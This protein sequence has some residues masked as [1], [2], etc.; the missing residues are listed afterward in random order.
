MPLNSSGPISIG[1]STTG[2]SIN[3][4]LDRSATQSTNLNETAMRSLSG[5]A[6]GTISLSNFYGVGVPTNQLISRLEGWRYTGSGTVL[7]DYSGVGNS[8]N[9]IN[10]PTWNGIGFRVSGTQGLDFNKPMVAGKNEVTVAVFAAF[11]D[12][13]S[14]STPNMAIIDEARGAYWQYSLY[15]SAFYTRDSSDTESRNNDLSGFATTI[16]NLGTT[17]S[18]FITRYSVSGGF[19][20]V[21]INK[22]N[23]FT[24]TTG[25]LTLSTSSSSRFMKIGIASDG[26]GFNGTIYAVYIYDRAISDTELNS[27]H[28]YV[29]S[30]IS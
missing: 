12:Q 28:N 27:L 3:L 29:M 5:V 4:E 6:S 2:Q 21:T 14:A 15:N 16:S 1:G 9:I 7:T 19:K 10:S 17:K 26:I 23:T 13:T 11:V 30:K 8:A 20:N 25:I 24:N 22:T 18:S